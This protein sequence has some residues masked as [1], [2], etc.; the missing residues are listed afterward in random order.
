MKTKSKK[1][2]PERG[3]TRRDFIKISGAATGFLL[4]GSTFDTLR[5]SKLLAQEISKDGDGTCSVS[6]T[7]LTVDDSLSPSDPMVFTYRLIGTMEARG[8]IWIKFPV[9]GG[10]TQNILWT[11]LKKCKVRCFINSQQVLPT[12]N[13]IGKKVIKLTQI[14]V[15]TQQTLIGTQEN[16]I[17]ITV[18]YPKL[19]SKPCNA[20][21]L[22]TF[23]RYPIGD[24][25]PGRLRWKVYSKIKTNGTFVL[26]SDANRPETQVD[27]ADFHRLLIFLPADAVSGVSFKVAVVAID[28]Y[29]NR[30][31]GFVGR[32]SFTNYSSFQGLPNYYD[33]TGVE[34]GIHVFE[35]VTFQDVG[36]IRVIATYEGKEYYSNPCYV[37]QTSPTYRS[38]FGDLH[39]HS[40]A[41]LDSNSKGDHRGEYVTPWETYRYAAEVMRLDFAAISDHDH[42]LRKWEQAWT[43]SKIISRDMVES[44]LA[45]R[46]FPDFVSFYAYEWTNSKTDPNGK[47]SPGHR[48][49]LYK[50]DDGELFSSRHDGKWRSLSD[51]F[52]SLDGQ[53]IADVLVI[54]HVMSN[55]YRPWLEPT[56]Q[57]QR[58]Q[59]I[60]EIYSHKNKKLGKDDNLMRFEGQAVQEPFPKC[61]YRYAWAQG[62]EIGV[63][64]STDNHLGQAGANNWTDDIE[65]AG[66]LA[67][68][69][70]TEGTRDAL[71]EALTERRTYATSGEKTY[72]HFSINGHLM[73]EKFYVPA[74]SVDLDIM[75]KAA[76]S[77]NIKKI[78]VFQLHNKEYTCIH[79]IQNINDWKYNPDSTPF[80]PPYHVDISPGET[81]MFYVR[82]LTVN[83]EA[84]WSSPIW[85]TGE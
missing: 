56:E 54:P 68:V 13:G 67:A 49:I 47:I 77:H 35:G 5:P 64:G 72:L 27:A 66:G 41:D 17:V 20:Q 26:L 84:A 63:I 28:R 71:W 6:K 83:S 21:N 40:N 2:E 7:W 75:V 59:K 57:C 58:Y 53:G 65:H 50:N 52:D 12:W 11:P 22:S 25:G 61:S 19:D 55:S 31:R 1:A 46:G 82:V 33:F 4:T 9:G 42:A 38:Y 60:G 45:Q 23:Y 79:N 34:E 80:S 29:G 18:Q 37:H 44:E 48:V 74:G 73:G 43:N 10:E 70:A 16:P 76:A 8:G 78:K 24:Y 15:K 32:V 39:F 81:Y 36:F 51:L 62:R 3:I 30:C 14:T 69:L 85:I